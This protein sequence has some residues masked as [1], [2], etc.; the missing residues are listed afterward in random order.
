M[1]SC[2]ENAIQEAM[3]ELDRQSYSRDEHEQDPSSSTS[4]EQ[5]ID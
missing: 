2:L 3:N 5:S 4:F 1:N